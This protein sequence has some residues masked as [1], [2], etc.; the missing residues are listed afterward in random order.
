MDQ[1]GMLLCC[2]GLATWTLKDSGGKMMKTTPKTSRKRR[3]RVLKK[4]MGRKEKVAPDGT[5]MA[6]HFLGIYAKFP[7]GT[8]FYYVLLLMVQKSGCHQLSLICISPF[9]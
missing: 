5:N 8:Q 4:M 2:L 6:R 1:G 9:L 7:G 3:V